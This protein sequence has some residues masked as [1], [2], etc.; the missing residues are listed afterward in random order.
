MLGLGTS[1]SS[2]YVPQSGSSYTNAYSV[3]FD[4]VDDFIDLNAPSNWES[5]LRNSFTI[6]TWIQLPPSSASGNQWLFSVKDSSQDLIR[7]YYSSGS[8]KIRHESDNVFDDITVTLAAETWFNFVYTVEKTGTGSDLTQ[9]VLYVNGSA[10]GTHTG[11]GGGGAMTAANQGALDISGGAN[12]KLADYVN[13]KGQF[14][15]HDFAIYSNVLTADNA[16]A[17]YNSG[18]SIDLGTDSGDYDKSGGL[19]Y[20]YKL[21]EGTG[22][23]ATDSAGSNNGTLTNGPSW[24]TDV[25]S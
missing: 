11:G 17:V 20:Y 15:M 23:T 4:G 2:L 25:P 14:I 5:I 1:L 21:D 9:H 18:T 12:F 24:V 22:T 7:W 13:A 19:V 8:L 3:S 16:V 6:S 10:T